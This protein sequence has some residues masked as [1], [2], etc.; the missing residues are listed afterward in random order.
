MNTFHLP[1]VTKASKSSW[2]TRKLSAKLK[3]ASSLL[4]FLFFFLSLFVFF[5]KKTNKKEKNKTNKQ[6]HGM[7]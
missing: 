4:L 5:L 2:K 3:N 7:P 1:V 6:K